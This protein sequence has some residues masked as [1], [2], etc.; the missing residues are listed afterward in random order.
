MESKSKGKTSIPRKKRK[1][2]FIKGRRGRGQIKGQEN[3]TTL[4]KKIKRSRAKTEKK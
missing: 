3:I 4:P 2:A 1:G